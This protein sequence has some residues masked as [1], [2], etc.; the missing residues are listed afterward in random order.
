MEKKRNSK[1]DTAMDLDLSGI[2]AQ[3][4]TEEDSSGELKEFNSFDMWE[5]KKAVIKDMQV[6][7]RLFEPMCCD[8]PSEKTEDT[9][10]NNNATTNRSLCK[11]NETIVCK[12]S[13]IASL[14]ETAAA[15]PNSTNGFAGMVKGLKEINTGL[16][17]L[18]K[19][20]EE[21]MEERKK[22]FESSLEDDEMWRRIMDDDILYEIKNVLTHN[23]DEDEDVDD[24]DDTM[25]QEQNEWAVNLN[26]PDGYSH[27]R[28]RDMSYPDLNAGKAKS[29]NGD[30]PTSMMGYND[31]MC[32]GD[33]YFDPGMLPYIEQRNASFDSYETAQKCYMYFQIILIIYLKFMLF[34]INFIFIGGA[35]SAASAVPET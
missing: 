29:V 35:G 7:P 11:G 24:E 23:S 1:L 10:T 30:R 27:V 19:R 12:K 32:Q 15:D 28:Q 34:L 22:S 4:A 3:Y 26:S 14:V 2:K 31:P 17:S 20:V 5:G 6:T 13:D 33:S 21:L 16:E 8:S 9:K 18:D 25:T